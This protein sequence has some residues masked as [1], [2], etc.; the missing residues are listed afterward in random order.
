MNKKYDRTDSERDQSRRLEQ[1][2]AAKQQ[3]KEKKKPMPGQQQAGDEAR[4]QH[5][6][7]GTEGDNRGAASGTARDADSGERVVDEP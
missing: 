3:Q 5:G 2:E 1:G 4:R 6:G 7:W